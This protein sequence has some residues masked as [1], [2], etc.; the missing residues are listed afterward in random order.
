[1]ISTVGQHPGPALKLSLLCDLGWAKTALTWVWNGHLARKANEGLSDPAAAQAAPRA[2]AQPE[3]AHPLSQPRQLHTWTPAAPYAVDPAPKAPRPAP[4]QRPAE[5]SR[6]AHRLAL[7][8]ACGPSPPCLPLLPAPVLASSPS[9]AP[10][11][12]LTR[13]SRFCNGFSRQPAAP[14]AT[15]AH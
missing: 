14:A 2:K 13:S 10:R 8:S 7:L 12:A 5:P 3:H 9:P 1:M 6:R 4:S 15:S 11:L